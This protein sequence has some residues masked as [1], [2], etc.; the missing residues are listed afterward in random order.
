MIIHHLHISLYAHHPKFSLLLSSD[1]VS[2][3]FSDIVTSN[4]YDWH[5]QPRISRHRLKVWACQPS[6]L[7]FASPCNSRFS[8]GQWPPGPAQTLFH[9]AV[10]VRGGPLLLGGVRL[11]PCPMGK[12][13]PNS[14]VSGSGADTGESLWRLRIWDIAMHAHWLRILTEIQI[15]I[16]PFLES[17]PPSQIH[18]I[19]SHCDWT[20]SNAALK[21]ILISLQFDLSGLFP[22][23]P[24]KYIGNFH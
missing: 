3:R 20:N 1:H 5:L 11:W 17:W 18:S 12:S 16:P 19:I 22:I 23:T 7:M 15:S 21:N 6:E 10:R 4:L 8:S 2:W 24:Q 9:C 14:N 13:L